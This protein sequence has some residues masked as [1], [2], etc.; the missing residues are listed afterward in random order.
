MSFDT[1]LCIV[2]IANA[3]VGTTEDSAGSTIYNEWY[4]NNYAESGHEAY[5]RTADWCAIFV[6]WCANSANI[7]TTVVP[8]TASA[9][10]MRN[11]YNNRAK[12]YTS[13]AYGGTYTPQAGDLFLPITLLNLR[14]M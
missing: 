6:A 1:I 9:P 3:Q 4:A 10:T 8:H 7:P 14:D 13:Q 2:N 11:F 5:W 12:F